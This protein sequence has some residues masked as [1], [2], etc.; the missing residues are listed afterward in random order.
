MRA[1]WDV[2]RLVLSGVWASTL[3]VVCY[4]ITLKQGNFHSTIKSSVSVLKLFLTK[5]RGQKYYACNVGHWQ[6]YCKSR[7]WWWWRGYFVMA[8]GDVTD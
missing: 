3:I 8:A 1:I 2:N 7:R 4:F 5:V 6:N